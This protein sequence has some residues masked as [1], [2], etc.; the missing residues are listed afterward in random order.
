MQAETNMGGDDIQDYYKSKNTITV[1]FKFIDT[2]D[3]EDIQ[4]RE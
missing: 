4:K 1:N 2:E 3:S